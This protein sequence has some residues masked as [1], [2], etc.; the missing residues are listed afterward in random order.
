MITLLDNRSKVIMDKVRSK[1]PTEDIYKKTGCPPLFTYA[2]SRLI[3]LQEH[4]PELFGK[5]ERYADLKSFLLERWTG[6][7]VTEP[8]IAAATQLLNV[9]TS[10][11]DDELLAWAG[12]T[13]YHL[14]KLVPGGEFSGTLTAQ[15]ADLLG[16]N[17]HTPVLPGLYDG[18]AMILGMGGY[19][20]NIAVCNLGTTAMMR[21]CAKEPLLDDPSKMRLQ[22]Y[23][24]LPGY[25]VTGG[26][27]NNAGVALRWYRDTLDPEVSYEALMAEAHEIKPGSEGLFCLPFL[28]G[29]RDPRIGDLASAVFFGLKEFHTKGHM[30]RSILEGVAYALNMV[31]EAAAENEFRPTLLR[32]GGSGA[33]SDL[34]ITIL[35]NIL[36]IKVQRMSTPEAAL[37]GVSMLGFTALGLYDSIETASE[38]MVQAGEI[39]SPSEKDIEIYSGCYSFFTRLV[40]TMQEMYALHKHI[41]NA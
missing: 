34:W 41:P 6:Q 14:P 27:L 24:L 21:G 32:I 29:E 26:A 40:E 22:T 10:D 3:W 36:N 37:I 4:K 12:I 8:S 18:G 38:N 13:R 28:T 35:A 15:A 33:K 17:E 5:A 7:F 1:F 9:H 19:G 23:P 11:W 16:L 25:W 2:F 31:R 30:A 39:F 20:E